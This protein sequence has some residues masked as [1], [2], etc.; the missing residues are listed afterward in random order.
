MSSLPKPEPT[1]EV[2]CAWTLMSRVSLPFP[3]CSSE[4]EIWGKAAQEG[5]G[6]GAC[7]HL[8]LSPSAHLHLVGTPHT[9]VPRQHKSLCQC[10]QDCRIPEPS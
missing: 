1:A 7:M 2:Q 3:L 6:D 5:M 8:A 10:C 9:R 4:G